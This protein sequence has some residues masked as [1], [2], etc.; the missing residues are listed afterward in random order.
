MR[1]EALS[2][3]RI[4]VSCTSCN[5]P[6]ELELEGTL[7]VAG[8]DTFNPFHC[9][10]LPEAESAPHGRAHPGGARDRVRLT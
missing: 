4:V 8:Y 3:V 5:R 9:P 2:P 7:G 10:A 1:F 6:V